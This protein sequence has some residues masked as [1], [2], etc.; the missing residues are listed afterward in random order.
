MRLIR[1]LTASD[2]NGPQR[3]VVREL[4]LV[5]IK[6]VTE[7]VVPILVVKTSEVEPAAGNIDETRKYH[8]RRLDAD[9]RE[10]AWRLLWERRR[11]SLCCRGR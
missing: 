7:I 2:V 3:S 11:P 5:P 9:D 8:I 1:R 4:I 10:V 6:R